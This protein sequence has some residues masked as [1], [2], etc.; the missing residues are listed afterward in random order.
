MEMGT[1]ILG[2]DMGGVLCGSIF[3]CPGAGINST[4][5]MHS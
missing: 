1:W 4:A 2:I 3:V 5:R